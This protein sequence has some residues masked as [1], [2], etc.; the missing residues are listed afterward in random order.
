MIQILITRTK[1]CGP[2]KSKFLIDAASQVLRSEKKHQ[3]N[4]HLIFTDDSEIQKINYMFLSHNYPTDVI[5]FPLESEPQL[6]AEI[7][8]SVE[9]A[10]RQAKEFH[11][12]L[13]N[14]LVR[15]IVH[16]ILHVCGYDDVNPR[17]VSKMK[18]KENFYIDTIFKQ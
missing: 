16:G 14:E 9:T 3:A 12:S 11:V 7:Y 17:A 4:I 10:R 15:L 2:I 8:I 18:A 1:P 5:T 13:A 6:E